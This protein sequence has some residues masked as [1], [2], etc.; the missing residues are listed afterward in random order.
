MASLKLWQAFNGIQQMIEIYD[1]L[2]LLSFL[3][4][5]NYWFVIAPHKYRRT[6]AQEG[7]ENPTTHFLRK[8]K[9]DVTYIQ[10]PCASRMTIMIFQAMVSELSGGRQGA[11]VTS[12]ANYNRNRSVSFF[13]FFH[14]S[15][16]GL[17][18]NMIRNRQCESYLTCTRGVFV[19]CVATFCCPLIFNTTQ[20]TFYLAI[21]HGV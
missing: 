18:Q 12:R 16:R 6:P 13:F 10:P 3:D 2:W 8:W 17:I 5:I 14:F 7:K 4:I 20:L 21:K 1:R 15:C 9:L 19:W 11:N